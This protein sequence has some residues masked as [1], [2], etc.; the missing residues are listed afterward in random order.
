M[1]LVL[2]ATSF[3]KVA[4]CA[5]DYVRPY[6]ITYSHIYR[7]SVVHRSIQ[8]NYVHYKSDCVYGW[9]EVPFLPL[10]ISLHI[11]VSPQMR[12]VSWIGQCTLYKEGQRSDDATMHMECAVN[13][14]LTFSFIHSD[15]HHALV[16]SNP[17]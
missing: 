12:H 1:L 17:H 16:P 11:S 3:S 7:S 5:G 10:N 9:N 8:T 2:G 14:T 13:R 15:N 6:M 4:R